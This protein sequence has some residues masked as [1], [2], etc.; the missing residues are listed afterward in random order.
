MARAGLAG[1]GRPPAAG[2]GAPAQSPVLSSPPGRRRAAGVSN[3]AHG[4]V[5]ALAENYTERVEMGS[6]EWRMMN[7]TCKSGKAREKPGNVPR[8]KLE[9]DQAPAVT[10]TSQSRRES[11]RKC[12]K[13]RGLQGSLNEDCSDSRRGSMAKGSQHSFPECAGP[14]A[15]L[16]D[17]DGGPRARGARGPHLGRDGQFPRGL[18]PGLGWPSAT[19]TT[20]PTGPGLGRPSTCE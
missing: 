4:A 17:M 9:W 14:G 15:R 3:E 11:Q 7:P 13:V 1:A 10:E 19:G 2:H 18:W 16:D 8:G 6:L 20:N 12:G 5:P